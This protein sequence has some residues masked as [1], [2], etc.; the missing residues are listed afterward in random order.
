MSVVCYQYLP[1]RYI[2]GKP[3]VP[4]SS[5]EKASQVYLELADLQK[6]GNWD[7]AVEFVVKAG[8]PN[9]ALLASNDWYR[10]RRSMEIIKV[11]Q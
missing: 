8:D 5:D 3:D 7:A 1:I 10:L 4:K 11:G 6:S 9:A 2:Y